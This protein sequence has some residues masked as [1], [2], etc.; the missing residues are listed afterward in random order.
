MQ[1]KVKSTLLDI[2][3]LF[4]A[5]ITLVLLTDRSGAAALALA[6]CLM[7]ECGH[8]ICM[9]LLGDYPYSVTLSF[10]GM[11]IE[12]RSGT[13][14]SHRDEMLIALSG[15]AVNFIAFT[16]FVS[17][18]QLKALAYANLLIGA[19]NSLPCFPLDGGRVLFNALLALM[20]YEKA[21]KICAAVS[22][23]VLC[24]LA[25]CSLVLLYASKNFT[26]LAVTLY[27]AVAAKTG[28]KYM[29]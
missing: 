25:V 26:L 20:K 9:L 23:A 7:H 10:F 29:V 21:E 17:F 15:P 19:F 11:R 27:L 24:A 2:R 8:L 13:G 6:A 16:V 22:A 1:I 14:I 4:A 28:K 18:E 3:V 12:R 5:C